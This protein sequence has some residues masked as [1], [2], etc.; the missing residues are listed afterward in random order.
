[1]ARAKLIPP[2]PVEPEVQL[3]MSQLQAK[4]LL[5]LL[6]NHVSGRPMVIRE[7]DNIHGALMNCISYQTFSQMGIE[8][9]KHESYNNVLR[10]K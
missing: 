4:Y 3:T 6:G 1:M 8:V 9:T 7:F 5:A 2:T 10:F